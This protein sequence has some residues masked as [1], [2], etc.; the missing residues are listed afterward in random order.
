MG[1]HWRNKFERADRSQWESKVARW[2][3]IFVWKTGILVQL[4]RV[5]KGIQRESK[6]NP[7]Q[8]KSKREFKENAKSQNCE[9][10]TCLKS[11][12]AFCAERWLWMSVLSL[13][14][15][16][17]E[18]IKTHGKCKNSGESRRN[19]EEKEEDQS[20]FGCISPCNRTMPR[21]QKS[22]GEDH[23]HMDWAARWKED[24]GAANLDRYI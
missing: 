21:G 19:N 6:E 22:K 20:C 3:G 23:C 13:W 14:K 16:K 4:M 7:K 17:K 15:K 2:T 10:E 8:W 24:E 18:A 12:R 9:I 5:Q 11:K 1:L